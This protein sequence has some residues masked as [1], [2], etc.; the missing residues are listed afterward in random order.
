MQCIYKGKS[1]GLQQISIGFKARM[2]NS[3]VG[4]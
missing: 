2:P 1:R 4:N 3:L